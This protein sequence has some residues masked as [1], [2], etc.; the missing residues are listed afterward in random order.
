MARVVRAGGTVAAYSWDMPGGGFPY[1]ALQDEM[2][3]LG[4]AVPL[5]PNPDASRLDALRE[6]W[7]GAGLADVATHAIEVQRTFADFAEW[8]AIVA[9]GPSVG[10]RLAAMSAADRERLA[11][12]MRERLPADRAGRLVC[13]ARANAIS[14]R[15]Q[16]TPR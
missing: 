5:P 14:G 4:I 10:A 7:A 16:G 13:G 9:G 11:E 8:W 1:Q 2:R 6:L 3:A 12:R 15:V